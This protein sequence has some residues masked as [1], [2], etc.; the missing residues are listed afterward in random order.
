MFSLPIAFIIIYLLHLFLVALFTRW[1]YQ[2]AIKRG[3]GEGIYDRNLDEE[4]QALDYYHFKSFL[5]KYPIFA[6]IRSPFPWLIAWELR[7]IGGNRIGKNSVIE[8]CYLHCLINLGKNCYLGTYTHLSNHLVDG[9]YGT[10]NLTHFGVELGNKV[11][12]EALTGAMPGTNIGDN[13]T[14]LPISA[15][16]KF[17]KLKGNAIYSFFPIKKLDLNEKKEI[18]GEDF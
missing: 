16:T 17:D 11:V 13:T 10:E 8:E 7:F 5:F 6:F 14:V 15:T 1:F 9:V 2:Y 3:S 4:S 18:L 12:F